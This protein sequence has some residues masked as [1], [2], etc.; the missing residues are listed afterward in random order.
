[1]DSLLLRKGIQFQACRMGNEGWSV[2]V[3]DPCVGYVTGEEL[4]TWG[5]VEEFALD[6]WSYL[7][8]HDRW[9]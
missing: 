9:Q 7:G 8:A 5:D 4:E 1:M 2:V 6:A 3:G